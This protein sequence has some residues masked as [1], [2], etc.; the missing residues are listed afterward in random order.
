MK[1]VLIQ[2]EVTCIL[3]QISIGLGECDLKF[4]PQTSIKAQAI[5]EFIV[6]FTDYL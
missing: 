5:V 2:L 4:Q 1:S 3:A 6:E